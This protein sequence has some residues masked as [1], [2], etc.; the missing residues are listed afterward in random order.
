VVDT[1]VYDSLSG[2]SLLSVQ[3]STS[4]T[5]VPDD[6]FEAYL[7]A[8]GMGNGIANDDSVLTANIDTVTNLNVDYLNISDLTGIEDFISLENLRCK[9]NNL[10]S[11]NV[12]N[13][14]YLLDLNCDNNYLTNLDLSSNTF[15]FDLDCDDNQI[16]SL[17]VS[18][19]QALT[20]LDCKRNMLTTINT[21]SNIVLEK[22][23]IKGNQINSLDLTNNINLYAIECDSN[24]LNFLDVKNGNNQLITTFSTFGNMNLYCINVDDSIYS[25][26]NWIS[27][28]PQHYFSNN[29]TPIIFGCTDSL[30]LNYNSLAT[31]DDSS[32]VYCDLSIDSL[33]VTQI[34][35]CSFNDATVDIIATGNQ[36]LPYNYYV[37]DAL[38]P[39]DTVSQGNISFSFGLSTGVYVAVVEDSLGCLDSDTFE[40]YICEPLKIDSVTA[41]NVSCNGGNDGSINI[42]ASG[43]TPP[44]FYS[45]N[46]MP[47]SNN[48]SFN[49]LSIGAYTA[50]V[51]DVHG[52]V[53]SEPIIIEEPTL[54]ISQQA[55][56]I[57]DGDSIIVVSSIYYSSG[58]YTDTLPAANGCDSVIYT[59]LLVNINTASYDTL[60]VSASIVWNGIPLNVSGDYSVTLINSV[61]CDSIANLNLT[62]TSTGI[63]DIAKNKINLVKITDMLGHETPFRKNTPL[64][65]IYDDGTVEKKITID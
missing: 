44:Y 5:Y 18:N 51:D 30:A 61:G 40:I 57:C 41:S 65:Y 28:D 1:L 25:A 21:S 53:Y 19:N 43:G 58:N 62:V 38:N 9:G 26:S 48:N 4:Q 17:D 52:C 59:D 15:L 36:P 23:D 14:L 35:C 34:T 12:S 37:Y 46:N 8:N 11:L 3:L 27:I 47:F 63:Y 56:T 32:C 60:S 31:I 39:T 20:S 2:W 33:I 6:N 64:L 42:F 24:N 55:L 16:I 50:A 54:I 45:L 13:N 22:I 10:T 7:E 49:G 29:C